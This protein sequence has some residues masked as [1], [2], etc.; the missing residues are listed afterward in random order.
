MNEKVTKFLPIIQSRVSDKVAGQILKMVKSGTL[1]PGEQLP[2]ERELS[3][4]LNVSRNAI[5]EAIRLL[6]AQGFLE[7]RQ[8]IGTFVLKSTGIDGF[9]ERWHKWLIEN[10][11]QVLNLLQVRCALE[12]LAASLAAKYATKEKIQAMKEVLV[13]IDNDI[14]GENIERAIDG[15][16]EFHKL[17][18]DCSNNSLLIELNKDINVALIENR[19]AYLSNK[20][21]AKMSN[22][23]HWKVFKAIQAKK[24]EDA[25]E[26]MREHI[27]IT[28]QNMINLIE[29]MEND[30]ESTQKRSN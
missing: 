9:S 23:Q 24:V 28:R 17:I 12:P 1:K 14:E 19:Y 10:K 22:E 18:S 8:G 30:S 11:Q 13:Q 20:K 7:V 2:S 5:R 27:V 3:N 16:V 15:D 25:A 21:R 6:E 4:Q 29:L 26:A